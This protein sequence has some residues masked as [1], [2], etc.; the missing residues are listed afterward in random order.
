MTGEPRGVDAVDSEIALTALLAAGVTAYPSPSLWFYRPVKLAAV[1]LLALTLAKRV[2]VLNGLTVDDTP[3]RWFTHL[4]D[5]PTYVAYLYLVWTATGYA[6]KVVAEPTPEMHTLA[7][8]VA[9]PI[10]TFGVFIASQLAFGGPLREGERIFAAS[11]EQ[12]QGEV[13]GAILRGISWFVADSRQPDTTPTR[14]T[15]LTEL[16]F[17]DRDL[18]E[19]TQDEQATLARSAGI[20]AT[21]LGIVLLVYAALIVGAVW[22]TGIVWWLAAVLLFA[23]LV[24][25]AYFRIWYSNYGLVRIENRNGYLTAVGDI[26]TYAFV[27]LLAA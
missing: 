5:P 23:V 22:F 4:M 8:A 13:L 25:S 19:L 9:V 2:A 27:L 20:T 18:S 21:S 15:K 6:L 12:H 3:L 11:A 1:G 7:F 26:I 14:Q 10:V 24:V 16:R 17:H